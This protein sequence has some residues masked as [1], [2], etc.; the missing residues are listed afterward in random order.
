MD[1]C[2]IAMCSWWLRYWMTQTQNKSM[3]TES[4]IRRCLYCNW[5]PNSDIHLCSVLLP[6][7][8]QL[9]KWNGG[10]SV[11]ALL[12]L[13]L[14]RSAPSLAFS[15]ISQHEWVQGLSW[16]RQKALWERNKHGLR[17][18]IFTFVDILSWSH[19]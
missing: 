18:G 13:S 1:K 9:L 19:Q 16:Q 7:C 8:P 11:S 4:S 5:P 3:T 12:F 15:L 17:Q 10:H 6:L 14:L 2:S